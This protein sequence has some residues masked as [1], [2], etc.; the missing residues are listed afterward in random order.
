MQMFNQSS[1]GENINV[2]VAGVLLLATKLGSFTF[3][4]TIASSELYLL[5]SVSVSTTYFEG[6][7]E[8]SK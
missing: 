7:C 8:R 3:S 6:Y 2:A 5:V 4:I 1:H